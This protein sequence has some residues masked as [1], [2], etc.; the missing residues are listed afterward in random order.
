LN[1]K[2]RRGIILAGTGRSFFKIRRKKV[3]L[4]EGEDSFLDRIKQATVEGRESGK[5]VSS[6]LKEKVVESKKFD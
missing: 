5:K 1:S 6:L 2:Q 4:T 3:I